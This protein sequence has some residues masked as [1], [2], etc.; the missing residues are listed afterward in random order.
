MPHP[1]R[2]PP[3]FETRCG[4]ARLLTERFDRML[5]G[6][7]AIGAAT[8]AGGLYLSFALNAASGA[9]IVLVGAGLFGLVLAGTWAATLRRRAPVVLAPARPLHEH[10]HEH[11]GLR[12]VH[13]HAHPLESHILGKG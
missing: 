13:P 10:A 2:W 11:D 3:P 8:G 5:L 6:S 9:T 4:A 12:H 1:I 7:A